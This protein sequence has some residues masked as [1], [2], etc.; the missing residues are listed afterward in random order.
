MFNSSC[1][2]LMVNDVKMYI[3]FSWPDFEFL[4]SG[5]PGQQR[6]KDGEVAKFGRPVSFS[7][8]NVNLCF[9]ELAFNVNGLVS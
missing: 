6:A 5:Y 8:L 1:W 3:C 7:L 2:A 9:L 4:C